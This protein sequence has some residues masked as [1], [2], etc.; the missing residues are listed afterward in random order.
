MTTA[1][2]VFAGPIAT[3]QVFLAEL[4]DGLYFRIEI[5][6]LGIVIIGVIGFI[7]D[8]TLLYMEI[9]LAGGQHRP[10]VPTDRKRPYQPD[11]VDK[12][13]FVV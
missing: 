11:R 1:S 12:D 3:F 9:K 6:T 2:A 8:K 4:S 5:V 10:A 7:L 13:V